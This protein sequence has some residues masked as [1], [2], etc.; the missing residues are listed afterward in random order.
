MLYTSLTDFDAP[1]EENSFNEYGGDTTAAAW[2]TDK[3]AF[4]GTNTPQRDPMKNW[5]LGEGRIGDRPLAPLRSR[6][7]VAGL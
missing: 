6:P 7:L 1:A 2:T 5:K 4:T 3:V